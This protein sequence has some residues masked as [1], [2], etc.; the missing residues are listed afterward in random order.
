MSGPI[1]NSPSNANSS[2][3]T[4]SPSNANSSSRTNSPLIL[5]PPS[6]DITNSVYLNNISSLLPINN[7]S[8]G[9]PVN[10]M[11]TSSN[12]SNKCDVNYNTV[13][14]S[15]SDADYN[16]L[17]NIMSPD[18]MNML[19]ILKTTTTIKSNPNNK[20]NTVTLCVDK[21]CPNGNNPVNFGKMINKNY[22]EYVCVFAPDQESNVDGSVSLKCKE[23]L[24]LKK[25]ESNLP[26]DVCVS[27]PN[28]Y[29]PNFQ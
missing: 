9:L 20:V 8:S 28:M 26:Y 25:E 29:L 7:I 21:K 5:N 14:Y 17:S 6:L 24:L 13:T 4:N 19:N 11:S 1:E 15:I 18:T 22:N 10:V 3:S 12:K 16:Q 23:S 27:L 2:S